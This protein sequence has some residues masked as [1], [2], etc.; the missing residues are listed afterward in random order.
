MTG[1]RW[2]A[3]IDTFWDSRGRFANR[4][5]MED[6]SIELEHYIRLRLWDKPPPHNIK[7]GGEQKNCP[8]FSSSGGFV[9]SRCRKE[10]A[11]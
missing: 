5:D 3:T 4:L 6:T 10:G 7:G 2:L 11:S 9:R 1:T 8:T